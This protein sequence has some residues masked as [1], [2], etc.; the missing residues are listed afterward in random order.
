MTAIAQKC[1]TRRKRRLVSEGYGARLHRAPKCHVEPSN[2]R[3]R[4]SRVHTHAA[5]ELV[6]SLKIAEMERELAR[7]KSKMQQLIHKD[8]EKQA[9][10]LLARLTPSNAKLKLW[11]EQSTPP[12]DL[13]ATAE[14]RPW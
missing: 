3:I 4:Q 9:E 13:S 8:E 2:T 6:Q 5:R 7:L 10:L 12:K 11:A 1:T 14:D